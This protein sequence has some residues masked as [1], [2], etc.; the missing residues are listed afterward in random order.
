MGSGV[1]TLVPEVVRFYTQKLTPISG[2]P[3]ISLD[4][5]IL[6]NYK[7]FSLFMNYL[8]HF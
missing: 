7:D 2:L 8:Y 4:H 6:N 1:Q 3:F 5:S